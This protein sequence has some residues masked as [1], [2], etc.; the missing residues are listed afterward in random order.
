M[1]DDDGIS[2]ELD[3]WST[4]CK[5]GFKVYKVFSNTGYKEKIIGYDS[6]NRLYKVE[7][8]NGDTEEFYYNEIDGH[9]N[10][11]KDPQVKQY[12]SCSGHRN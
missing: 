7:Y 5:L 9:R 10:Q 1:D 6:K 4:H 3:N 11:S 8:N 2:N 12:I